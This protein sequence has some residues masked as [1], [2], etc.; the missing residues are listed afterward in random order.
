MAGCFCL[1]VCFT[2][3]VCKMLEFQIFQFGMISIQTI[4]N[5]KGKKLKQQA[6]SPQQFECFRQGVE[7]MSR[8]MESD[9]KSCYVKESLQVKLKSEDFKNPF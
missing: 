5:N 2:I 9:Y 3:V 1:F 6:L 4:R 7:L 8:N